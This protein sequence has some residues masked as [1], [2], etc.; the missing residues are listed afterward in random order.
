M[1]FKIC[2]AFLGIINS[3]VADAVTSV[4]VYFTS[5]CASV[6]TKVN[7]SVENWKNTPLITGRKSSFPEAKRVA[8]MAVAK[9]SP[10]T[11]VLLG[12]FRCTAFGNSSPAR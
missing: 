12:S 2:N 5:L 11:T 10:I 1:P 3:A 4:R 6:A 7:P 8:L 9:V